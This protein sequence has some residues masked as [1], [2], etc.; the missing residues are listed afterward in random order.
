MM[1]VIRHKHDHAINTWYHGS[2]INSSYGFT[3]EYLTT[4]SYNC[5]IKYGKPEYNPYNNTFV[6]INQ[7]VS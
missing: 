5:Q 1:N 7:L 2:L 3:A 4:Q 6:T